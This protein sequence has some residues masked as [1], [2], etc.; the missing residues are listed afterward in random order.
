MVCA[1][2]TAMIS[3]LACNPEI[4]HGQSAEI[5][6]KCKGR[7]A[8]RLPANVLFYRAPIQGEMS[9]LA[10]NTLE[11]DLHA[12]RPNGKLLMDITNC[13]SCGKSLPFNIL[14]LF[15]CHGSLLDDRSK[16]GCLLV[17]VPS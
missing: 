13:P 5:L 17:N 7:T 1:G 10:P 15:W 2:K 12:N 16:L 4:V 9:L 8:N 14:G 3:I 6:F 11:R